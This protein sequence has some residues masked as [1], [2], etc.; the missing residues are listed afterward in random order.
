MNH[1]V[2][3]LGLK[4][5]LRASDDDRETTEETIRLV[6]AL[7]E[8]AEKRSGNPMPGIPHQIA[9]LALLDL[10][11]EYVQSQK[12]AGELLAE[13]RARIRALMEPEK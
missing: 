8:K 10:A 1:E 2:E 9:L 7:L 13:A 6:T 4:I 12:R 3:L 5:K 11:E